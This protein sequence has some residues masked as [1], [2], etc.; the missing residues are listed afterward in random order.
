MGELFAS[1]IKQFA[2]AICISTTRNSPFARELLNLEKLNVIHKYGR[3]YLQVE[4]DY[5]QEVYSMDINLIPRL[6]REF[7]NIEESW[8]F[9]KA[10]GRRTGV[11]KPDKRDAQT[12]KP[13]DEIRTGC[14]GR[15][16]VKNVNG[17]FK[18]NEVFL[19]HNH[20]LQPPEAVHLFASYQGLTP[21]Q[22]YEL[23]NAEKVGISQKSAFNLQSQYAGGRNNLGF[24]RVDVK[25][26]LNSKR[27]RAMGYDEAGCIF[28]YFEQLLAENPS[29]FHAHQMDSNEQ[30]TNVFWA[31]ARMLVDYACFGEVISLDTTYCTNREYRPL[32]IFSGFNHYR[33]GII[34]GV[35]L[36]YDETV[37]SFKWLFDTFLC[38]H[39]N[40]RPLTVFTDQDAAMSRALQEVMLD[41]KHALCTWHISNNAMKHLPNSMADFETLDRLPRLIL[42][43]SSML[44]QLAEDYTRPIFDLFQYQCDLRDATRI[45]ERKERKIT[46]N[47]DSA[48]VFD[49]VIT[50]DNSKWEHSLTF[51]PSTETITCSCKK[52]E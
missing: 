31:D 48:T 11:K 22:R 18:I 50:M 15:M 25:N 35:A 49:Y 39:K 14:K 21:A 42:Q 13:R 47:N 26:Y 43:S 36:L 37:E 38:A 30:V 44:H 41:V 17:K 4:L 7:D 3:H 52:F 23:E 6:D 9:W 8:E 5:L 19:D 27:Q 24:T 34:F 28:R 40:A 32:A 10:Y 2:R 45:K 51:E 16:K 1:G 12:R 33:K 29:F 46:M 20:P